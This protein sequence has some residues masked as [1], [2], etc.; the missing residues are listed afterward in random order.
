MTTS[1]KPRR[2]VLCP[3]CGAKSRVLY[4]EFGGYQTR[5]CQN[6]HEFNH[7]KWI[8]DRSFWIG[9]DLSPGA[10]RSKR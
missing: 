1:K 7:D 4:S 10:G 3:Q 9:L 2:F 5:L 8:A 6:G